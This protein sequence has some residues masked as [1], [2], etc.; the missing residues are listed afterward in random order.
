MSISSDFLF[1]LRYTRKHSRLSDFRRDLQYVR[2]GMTRD[3][4]RWLARHAASGFVSR[5]IVA[6]RGRLTVLHKDVTIDLQVIIV[7]LDQGVW[8]KCRTPLASICCGFGVVRHVVQQAV[9]QIHKAMWHIHVYAA[10]YNYL[11]TRSHYISWRRVY[12]HHS[13][14]SCL[15]QTCQ[16]Q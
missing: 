13:P 6:S 1:R 8:L 4:R 16:S 12:C 11:Q 2:V 7:G 9:R 14:T 3:R 15:Q 5:H 10:N